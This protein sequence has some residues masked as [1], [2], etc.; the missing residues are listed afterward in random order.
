MDPLPGNFPARNRVIAGLSRG[1]IVAQATQ[2]SG[3][4][5]TAQFALN[6]GREVFAVPGNIDNPLSAGCNKLISQGATLVTSAADV[7]ASF[8]HD[9]QQQTIPFENKEQEV[10]I[11]NCS[12]AQKIVRLCAQPIAFEE[13]IIQ[14]GMNEGELQDLLCDLSLEARVMQNRIGLWQV[15]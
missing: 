5:I 9:A 15:V 14:T 6:E 11:D 3:A 4:L 2:P 10:N 12:P 1:C 7:L 8:G 13:L